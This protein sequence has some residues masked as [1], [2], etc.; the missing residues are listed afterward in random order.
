LVDLRYP[1]QIFS[2][3][4][5]SRNLILATLPGTYECFDLLLRSYSRNHMY[6]RLTEI[7]L[8][9]ASSQIFVDLQYQ[10]IWES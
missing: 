3:N 2:E 8:S 1:G 4:P 5:I 7:K 6:L 10:G 9:L